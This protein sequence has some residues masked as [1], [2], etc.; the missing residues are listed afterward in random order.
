MKIIAM[1]LGLSILLLAFSALAVIPPDPRVDPFY[2]E[3]E[4][5]GP[6]SKATAVSAV[7]AFFSVLAG[8]GL[9]GET[10]SR[11]MPR[12]E[13]LFGC[14]FHFLLFPVGIAIMLLIRPIVSAVFSAL[15]GPSWN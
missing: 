14:L 15:F 6:V 11:K 7:I 8:M 1:L 10:L 9:L 5:S 3:D 12:K 13:G 2:D 4:D